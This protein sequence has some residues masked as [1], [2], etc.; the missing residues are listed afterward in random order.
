MSEH[1]SFDRDT[2]GVHY[3][4]WRNVIAAGCLGEKEQF[5]GTNPEP[6]PGRKIAGRYQDHNFIQVVQPLQVFRPITLAGGSKAVMQKNGFMKNIVDPVSRGLKGVVLAATEKNLKVKAV[7]SGHSFSDV[8]TT[9]DFLVVTD[10]LNEMLTRARETVAPNIRHANFLKDPIRRFGYAAFIGGL[11][12]TKESS[13]QKFYGKPEDKPCLVEFEAGI[14]IENLNEQLW[15][16]GWSLYNM[17][18]YQGQSFI[19]AASTATHGSGHTLPPLPDMIRSMVIVADQGMVFRI[20]PT[21]GITQYG[22]AA[23]EADFI[24]PENIVEGFKNLISN[25]RIFRTNEEHVDF[26]IQ[27]DDWFASAMVNVGTFGLVYSVIIEVVPRYY[28][29]ETVE[30]STW[31]NVKERLEDQNGFLLD[32][33]KNTGRSELLEKKEFTAL[34]PAEKWLGCEENPAGKNT[35]SVSDI[36]QTTIEINP[37]PSIGADGKPYHICRIMRQYQVKDSS[38]ASRWTSPYKGRLADDVELA[39]LTLALTRSSLNAAWEN[40]FHNQEKQEK[41]FED[42]VNLSSVA[43]LRP[44]SGKILEAVAVLANSANRIQ[45]VIAN[46]PEE[47]TCREHYLNRNYRTQFIPLFPGYGVELGFTTRPLPEF[48]NKP[49]YIAAMDR[50]LELADQHWDMGRYMQSSPLALR[51]VKKSNAYLAMQY[52]ESDEPTCMI[53]LLNQQD[54]HGGKELFYRYQRELF[55]YGARPHWGLDLSVTTGNN[56]LLEKMYPKF[57]EWLNVYKSLNASGTFNNRFTDRMGL[58]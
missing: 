22:A 36:R 15:D 27:D 10:D 30:F 21:D 13:S 29:L 3:R 40:V 4:T 48:G 18:T 43:V 28:L 24:D 1:I 55:R 37:H 7:G 57:P 33:E 41:W 14:K 26:L 44:V 54:T 2:L 19:G 23:G 45:Q 25:K 49:G 58:S 16:L 56:G 50:V 32:D 52:S 38:F 42:N 47:P 35:L 46:A 53:E 20:E 5:D 9:S 51:M 11:G 31:E 39:Q 12:I 17:G 6:I 34:F 8:A